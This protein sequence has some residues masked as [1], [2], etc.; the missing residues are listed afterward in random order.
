MAET[1]LDVLLRRLGLGSRKE[2]HLLA[3]AGRVTVDGCAVT[4]ASCRVPEGAAVA[5]D[6][7]AVTEKPPVCLMLHKPAG[8]ICATVSSEEKTVLDLLPPDCQTLLPVGRLDKDTTGLLL[9]T[10]D[11]ALCRRLIRPESGIWKAYRFTLAR[12]FPA[13]AEAEFARGVTL[14]NGETCL[15]ARLALAKDRLSGTV[16]L[17]EGKRHQVRRMAAAMDSRVRTLCR[18]AI[19]GLRLDESLAPGEYRPLTGAELEKLEEEPLWK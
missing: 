7:Q 14:E 17:R 1:R 5:V 12:P 15:P 3:A 13:G 19:G 16:W 2:V 18:T 6:G 11:G 8:V 4:D 9:I 10:D